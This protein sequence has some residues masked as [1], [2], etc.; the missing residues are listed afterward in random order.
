MER[1]KK[2]NRQG[3]IIPREY[4][5]KLNNYHYQFYKNNQDIVKLMF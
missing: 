3:E 5:E 2:R 1:I 4:Q